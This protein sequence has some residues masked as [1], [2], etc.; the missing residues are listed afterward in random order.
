MNQ[1]P[2]PEACGC[3]YPTLRTFPEAGLY[4]FESNPKVQQYKNALRWRIT[5]LPPLTVR[6]SV[7]KLFRSKADSSFTQSWW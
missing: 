6:V 7:T 1:T 4:A 2:R 5:L 3:R